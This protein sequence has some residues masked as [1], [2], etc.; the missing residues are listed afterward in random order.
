MLANADT[1]A[2]VTPHRSPWSILRHR[3]GS[4]LT[5]LLSDYLRRRAV[6]AMMAMDDRALKD[7]GLHRSEIL[8]VVHQGRDHPRE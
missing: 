8:A 3:V 5:S 4:A 6:R 2:P 1:R 7:I